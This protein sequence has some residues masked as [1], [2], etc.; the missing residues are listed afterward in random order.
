MLFFKP[1]S[2]PSEILPPPHP[3][4][5]LELE[6][7]SLFEDSKITPV[8][9]SQLPENQKFFDEIVNP[10]KAETFPEE[11]EFK[12]LV[13]GVEQEPSQK[14]SGKKGK[15]LEEMP[16]KKPKT[17]EK[18]K[19][20]QKIATLKQMRE[21]NT[22]EKQNPKMK[23]ESKKIDE[24]AE[25]KEDLGMQDIDFEL[26][27]GFKLPDKL[28]DF[29][30]EGF[31]EEAS[32][33]PAEILEAQEEIKSAIENIKKQ[34]QPSFLK[35][36]FVKKPKQESNEE[37]PQLDKISVIQNNIKKARDALMRYDMETAK[38]SYLEIMRLY[39]Q[40]KPEE[41]ARVYNDIKD[42]YAERKSAEELRA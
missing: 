19:P 37:L 5:D 23:K 39:S 25:F 38:A 9:H 24:A 6:K 21:K 4:S 17:L 20:K 27:K 22:I 2:K 11:R 34:E 18:I 10:N 3:D 7:P 12:D 41:Q 31:G 16:L 32:K 8:I 1:K 29:H 28:E 36:L 40:I 13:K 15:I 35:R 33:K 30:L 26:P 42:L 14:K